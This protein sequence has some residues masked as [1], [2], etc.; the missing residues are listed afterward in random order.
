MARLVTSAMSVDVCFVHALD[1]DE[2]GLTLVGASPPFGTEVG[3]VRLALGEGVSGWVAAHQAPAVIVE[4][5]LSDPRYRYIPGLRG[6]EYVS[7]ASV[8]M[9]ARPG[10]LA[11]VI[12]VHTRQRR[13]FGEEDLALLTGIGQ[14]MAGAV[15]A[16]RLHRRLRGHQQEYEALVERFLAVQE[17]ERR[18]IAAEVHDGVTQT[19]VSLRFH[20]SAAAD[21]MS[22]DVEFASEQV[23]AARGLA[24]LAMAEAR[25]AVEGLRPPMLDDLGLEAALQALAASLTR[26]LQVSCQLGPGALDGRAV[27]DHVVVAIYRIA[28]EALQNVTKHAGATKA[29]LELTS[30]GDDLVLRVKDDGEGFEPSQA[31]TGF[32]LKSIRERAELLGGSLAVRSAPGRGTELT[33]RL[34]VPGTPTS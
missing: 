4:D 20:L 24:D 18:R 32:G 34:P 28:Q 9:V 27:P 12:N 22:E 23:I 2:R 3:K 8:P 11:G 13:E 5:K 31:G 26:G 30:M 7:M 10:G 6:L 25:A 17:E 14:L 21:A 29:S 19:L 33:V 16:A 15:H 1:D